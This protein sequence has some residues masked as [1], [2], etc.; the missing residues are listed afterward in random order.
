MKHFN[1]S[2]YA[3]ELMT[4]PSICV[5]SNHE[6]FSTNQG[7]R[8]IPIVLLMHRDRRLIWVLTVLTYLRVQLAL[9]SLLELVPQC[10]KD[11]LYS[12]QL[13][14]WTTCLTQSRWQLCRLRWDRTALNWYSFVSR[15]LSSPQPFS[16]RSF[17]KK[18]K[19]HD[20]KLRKNCCQIDR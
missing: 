4:P 2:E 15:R 17:I 6:R 8:N 10:Y 3:Y 13:H 20:L 14:T 11:L 9:L 1:H 5:Y 19:T 16:F 18:T 7:A 12:I